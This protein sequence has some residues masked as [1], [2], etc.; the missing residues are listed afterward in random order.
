M[1]CSGAKA[2]SKTIVVQLGQETI[3]RLRAPTSLGLTSAT[4]R[5]T[6]GSMRNA[7]EL[8]ITTAPAASATGIHSRARSSSTSTMIRSRPANAAAVGSMQATSPTGVLILR[9]TERS[10]AKTRSSSIGNERAA[11]IARTS[12][13]TTPV[14]PNTPKFTATRPMQTLREA[15]RPLF[16]DLR[17][18]LHRKYELKK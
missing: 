12:S 17:R 14:A 10:E 11:R 5:G 8:S 9:P 4:T 13:P 3:L 6:P 16:L 15:P 2:V 18:P 1:R 7:A